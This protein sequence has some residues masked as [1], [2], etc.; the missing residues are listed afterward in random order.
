[1][2]FRGFVTFAVLQFF[3]NLVWHRGPLLKF[4]DAGT[5]TIGDAHFVGYVSAFGLFMIAG[6]LVTW[7]GMPTLPQIFWYGFAL[8]A[9]SYN[10][11][12]LT[13]AKH[14]L[15]FLPLSGIPF[16]AMFFK[17]KAHARIGMAV[18]IVCLAIGSSFYM[19][20]AAAFE[21]RTI[22]DYVRAAKYSGKGYVF[23]AMHHQLPRDIPFYLLGAGPGN[24]CSS[25]ACRSFRPLAVKYVLPY[26]IKAIRSRGYSAESSVIGTPRT[27]YFTLW[28]EFGPISTA[29]YVW[30]WGFA[31]WH[32]WRAARDD[33]ELSLETG[34][35]LAIISCLFLIFLLG[36]LLEV[37]YTG[38][39]I[40]PTWSLIGIYWDDDKKGKE[41]AK[42][43]SQVASPVVRGRMAPLQPRL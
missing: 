38:I 20:H 14:V 28:G 3:M 23:R 4:A 11:V 10:L 26:V 19:V 21:G 8:L 16:L 9:T 15:F 7:R 27:S 37:F 42:K 43:S 2:F 35:R 36:G 18:A 1:M 25:V 6:R 5:G 30:F 31:A 33:D 29:V 41:T 24:F 12:F 22:Q 17:L 40:L 13:D 39:L 32:L 34:Q